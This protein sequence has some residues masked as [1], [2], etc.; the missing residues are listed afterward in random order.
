M[1]RRFYIV[2]GLV[3]ILLFFAAWF[4]NNSNRQSQFSIEGEFKRWSKVTFVYKGPQSSE[5][6][7]INPFLNY[8]I[9]AEISNKSSVY[10]IN[11]Y[12]AADGNAAHTSAK[13]GSI[14]KLHF[15]PPDTGIWNY[16]IAFR[17]GNN[18]NIEKL[19]EIK[20]Q[21]VYTH[22]GSFYISETEIDTGSFYG[23]GFLSKDK[24]GKFYLPFKNKYF[25]KVG[26]NSPENFL[27]YAG[28]DQTRPTHLYKNHLKDYKGSDYLWQGRGSEIL[29]AVDYL[30]LQ[31]INS[32]YFIVMT[33]MGDGD[34]VWPWISREERYRYDCSKLDQWEL[35]FEYMQSKGM[36]IHFV[37]NET[38]NE[39][40]LDGGY[41]DVQRKL[42]YKE[43]IARFAHHPGLI[44][45]LGE[46]IGPAFFSPIGLP[47]THILLFADHIR[48]I[49]P[50]EHLIFIH[51]LPT[52]V[53]KDIILIPLLGQANIDGI[54][55]YLDPRVDFLE[56]VKRWEKA[57]GEADNRWIVSTD[58]FA[59]PYKGIVPDEYSEDNHDKMM[60]VF[61]ALLKH[62]IPG[63][64]WNF[65]ANF[66]HNDQNCEDFRSRHLFWTKMQEKIKMMVDTSKYIY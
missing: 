33:V 2:S 56:E 32:M 16:T 52:P 19:S 11:G 24:S 12:Y 46:Q 58:E 43:L 49:D 17:E 9:D 15:M 21:P 28:F 27:A 5:I 30:H 60:D 59:P 65:G 42:F 66:P 48:S 25:L 45:N 7:E 4:F 63:V 55:L 22:T 6:G 26:V 51:T 53:Q 18:I 64:E 31:G 54:S 36:M 61:E 3:I 1:K 39:C 47:A 35:L 13:E 37:F 44:W 10:H 40:L 20:T 62:N 23:Y 57:S 38:E 41:L 29:G 50:Y 8:R 14:W 34:D